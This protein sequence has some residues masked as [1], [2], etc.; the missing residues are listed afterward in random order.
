MLIS[1]LLLYS[2]SGKAQYRIIAYTTSS[3]SIVARYPVNKLT[4]IIFSFLRIQGDTLCFATEN[5]HK[6]LQGIVALKKQNP[7]L[8]I[9]VS[10]GGWGGCY[11]CSDLFSSD[12][13]RK[14]FART[15]VALFRE[16]NIDGLD[17]DWEYPAIEGY[18][19]HP[20]KISDREN[21]TELLKA[22]RTEMGDRY[23]LSFAAG[24]FISYLEQSIDWKTVMPLIDMVNLMT[25]D[26]VGGYSSVTG[27]HS[28][29]YSGNATAQSADR[30]ISWL[31]EKGVPPNKLIMGSAFYARVWQQVE[32][33]QHGL[34]Q[35]GKFF[36]GVA[37]KQFNQYFSDSS[38]YNYYWD[39]K[40]RSPWQYS[41]SKKLFATFDD[42]RSVTEKLKYIKRRNLGGIMF[43]ELADD[44]EN[45]GLIELMYHKLKR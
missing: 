25:Y 19:G 36:R 37:Y 1:L 23:L 30:A 18:P 24:G 39:K 15:T 20:Y 16:N 9:M 4:H 34:Y 22:L 14:M 38:G 3:D 12:A 8:K 42:E 29:L 28:P 44:K 11:G 27:H 43:W 33:S 10:I 45:N 41:S 2:L 7:S 5:Q 13:H 21:F 26:L 17:L 35:S 31:I 32:G 40:A 6:A